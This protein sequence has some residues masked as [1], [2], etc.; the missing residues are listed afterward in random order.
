MDKRL[1]LI[2][3]LLLASMAV[4]GLFASAAQARSN[5]PRAELLTLPELP[6]P[7]GSIPQHPLSGKVAPADPSVLYV[8]PGG[9][10]GGMSP[11]YGSVQAAVDD[12]SDGDVIKVA[13]G[14]YTGVKN[15]P[16]LNTATFTATQVVVIT[17]TVTIPGGYT[18]AFTEPPDP[19]ANPTT[20]DA[21]GQGRVVY[22]TGDISPTIKGLRITGGDAHGLGEVHPPPLWSFDGGGGMYILNATATIKN[23]Q[24]FNNTADKGGGLYLDV[25]AAVFGGNTV[26]SNTANYG[27]GLYLSRGAPTLSGNI[28]SANIG[29]IDGGG[30]NFQASDA[31]LNGNTI[32]SNTSCFG[33]G[34]FLVGGTPTLSGNAVISNT[35]GTGGGL[36]LHSSAATLVNNV[37]ADNRYVT[38][39]PPSLGGASN[40]DLMDTILVSHT[41]GISVTE[42]NNVTVDGVLWHGTP[43]T[44]SR[45]ALTN[46]TVHD[47]HEGDPAFAPDG[48]HLTAGSAAI[49][50]G[51]DAGVTTDI[52]GHHRPYG[53]APDLGADEIIAASL[54]PSIESTLVYTDAQGNPTVIQVPAGAVAEATTLVYTPVETATAPSGFAF[55]SHAFDLE[56][57]RGGSLLLG[58][59]FEKPV[60]VTIHYSDTDVTGLDEDALVLE[61]WNEV[62][63]AWEDAACGPYDRHPDD[64]WLAVPICHLSRFALFGETL[65]EEY[66]VYLP[67]IL[68]NH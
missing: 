40:V 18:T 14:V 61:Y 22:I 7:E 49:D 44:V 50:K 32:I 15:V 59:I 26:I 42:C 3:S 56:A 35:A 13:T 41:V 63:S 2:L 67:L 16:S 47:Q 19:D 28:V 62:T 24:I 6:F 54:P 5:L 17:K 10:C 46:V 29:T 11:C 1:L 37:V 53:S 57:Y 27:G 4:V 39:Y 36:W 43:I 9:D 65:G 45:A 23:N 51:V 12:A 34:L 25:S 58:F 30:L 55:A 31:V 20:L 8:A 33:G 52:D 21:Q 60:T 64:N 48:Y 38:Q 66:T 68:R